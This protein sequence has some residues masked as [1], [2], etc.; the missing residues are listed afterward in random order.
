MATENIDFTRRPEMYC[1][2]DDKGT[3]YFAVK[4]SGIVMSDFLLLERNLRYTNFGMN[5][6]EEKTG[7]YGFIMSSRM[8]IRMVAAGEKFR[9]H[10]HADVK[11]KY[12]CVKR[13]ILLPCFYD[14][15]VFLHQIAV[16]KL[17]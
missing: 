15:E 16:M 2:A 17:Y 11:N 4:D 8:E 5:L 7:T 12:T 14:F 1:F 6:N 3:F 9:R 13:E 10:C